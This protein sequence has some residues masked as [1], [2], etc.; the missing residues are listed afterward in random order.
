MLFYL[1]KVKIAETELKVN[2]LFTSYSSS[3]FAVA[4]SSKQTCVKNGL[5][6]CSLCQLIWDKNR[7]IFILLNKKSGFFSSL[8]VLRLTD[9]PKSNFVSAT[10]C[11]EDLGLALE[12]VV[13]R[14]IWSFFCKAAVICLWS[15]STQYVMSRLESIHKSEVSIIQT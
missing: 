9:L 5:I 1:K 3:F 11:I 7:F 6:D 14:L 12:N 13:S 15:V 8:S 2:F 10:E 4:V